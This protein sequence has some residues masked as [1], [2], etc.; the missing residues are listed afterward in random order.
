M[1][2]TITEADFK[3]CRILN[4]FFTNRKLITDYRLLFTN[5]L[6]I[7]YLKITSHYVQQ[8]TALLF[9]LRAARLFL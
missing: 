5:K 9:R 1:N 4:I 6:F 3:F 8:R 2:N 7:F